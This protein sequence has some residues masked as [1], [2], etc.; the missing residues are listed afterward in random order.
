MLIVTR[1]PPRR[2]NYVQ[3]TVDRGIIAPARL[4]GVHAVVNLAGAPLATRPWTRRRQQVL[5]DSRVKA[6]GSLFKSLA[7]LDEPPRVFV[8]AGHLGL[9]GDRGEE[10]VSEHTPPAE[11][12]LAELAGDWERAQLDG[13]EALGCRGAVVR[14]NIVL[15]PDGQLFP[16]LLLPFRNGFGGWLGDGTQW[17]SWLS[18]RDAVGIMLH[19]IDHG[20]AHGA[21][22]ATVPEP[23]RQRGLVR[24]PRGCSAAPAAS[25]GW[26]S[27]L[28]PARRL[29]S[30]GGQHPAVVDARRTPTPSRGGLHLS[31]HRPGGDLP[32]AGESSRRPELLTERTPDGPTPGTHFPTPPR[33]RGAVVQRGNRDSARARR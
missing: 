30:A 4:E 29:R 16:A 24:G 31:R 33:P 12:F 9:F 23:V 8:G 13:A 10:L 19:V 20:E 25:G 28:G 2:D 32:V 1:K 5:R 15:A 11:G 22:N 14:M 3:W 26:G 21:Y 6:T 17:L 27:A 18:V 7:R